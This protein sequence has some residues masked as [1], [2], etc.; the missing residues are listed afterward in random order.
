MLA[1]GVVYLHYTMFIVF[2][3]TGKL[4]A[5][6]WMLDTTAGTATTTDHT[7]LYGHSSRFF[8][9]YGNCDKWILI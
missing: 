6:D 7:L 1:K 9:S 8:W 4:P 3:Y 5:I 2:P